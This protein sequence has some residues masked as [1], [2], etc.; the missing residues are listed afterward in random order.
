MGSGYDQRQRVTARL[1]ANLR[2]EGRSLSEI[3]KAT[4]IPKDK[5]PDR[6]KLG[7]RLLSLDADAH[8]GGKP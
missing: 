4:G 8:S 1:A 3:A 7:E 2:R 6:I 5:V